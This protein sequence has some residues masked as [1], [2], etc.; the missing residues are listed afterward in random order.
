MSRMYRWRVAVAGFF[1]QMTLGSVYA[2]SVFKAPLTRQFN[3]A[4]P[5]VTFAF[6]VAIFVLG[7]AAFVCGFWMKRVGPRAIAILVD[8]STDLASFWPASAVTASDG[9]TVP[10][11]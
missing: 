6:T 9:F 8:F 10:S 11:A 7:I 3:W 2:W 4:T 5:N 1:L